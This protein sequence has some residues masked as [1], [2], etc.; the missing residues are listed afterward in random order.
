MMALLFQALLPVV[1]QPRPE[2]AAA[3]VPDWILSSLCR[4]GVSL[5]TV[6][7]AADQ[8]DRQPATPKMPTCPICP[9]CLAAQ[10][11]GL[12]FLP[13]VPAALLLPAQSEAI[14][15]SA[16]PVARILAA[17]IRSPQARAPPLPM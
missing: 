13:P 4:G 9:I 11:A 5:D 17:R 14:R 10:F 1:H 6:A 15:F 2:S 3:D 16:I 12:L 7:I 8:I